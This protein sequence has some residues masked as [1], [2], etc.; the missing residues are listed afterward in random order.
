MLKIMVKNPKV[1]TARDSKRTLVTKNPSLPH[2]RIIDQ[3]AGNLAGRVSN[4]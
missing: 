3:E 2:I 4:L 1:L